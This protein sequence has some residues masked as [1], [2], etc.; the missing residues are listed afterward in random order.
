[1]IRIAIIFIAAI[2]A[3]FEATQHQHFSAVLAWFSLGI[4]LIVDWFLLDF[5]EQHIEHLEDIIY[6]QREDLIK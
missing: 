3:I 4:A 2:L 5:Q 1:M 6:R